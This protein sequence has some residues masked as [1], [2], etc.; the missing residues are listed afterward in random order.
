MVAQEANEELKGG[1]L[2]DEMGMGKVLANNFFI[3]ACVH[4]GY[5]VDYPDNCNNSCGYE[6]RKREQEKDSS[7]FGDLPIIGRNKAL[8]NTIVKL[9]LGNVAMG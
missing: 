8:L 2:A 6:Q 1:I 3:Y 5:F 7:N 4:I 9:L